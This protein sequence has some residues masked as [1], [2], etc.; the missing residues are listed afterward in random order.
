PAV[1]SAREAARRTQCQNNLKQLGLAALNHADARKQYPTGGWAPFWIGDP[2]RGS[3]PQQ[4][5]GW[6]FN[7][8]PFFEEVSLYELGKGL[9]APAKQTQI[10]RR[11]QMALQVLNCPSRRS[12]TGLPLQAGRQPYDA[13]T[14]VLPTNQ[15][16]V[17]RSDY[18]ANSGR[19][20]LATGVS[21][22]GTN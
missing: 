3:G 11:A 4:H 16:G 20:Y 15:A 19:R 9:T 22:D 13:A 21:I 2:D 5:G 7:L 18:A 1:Q 14:L 10:A 12:G 8:L 17:A 6:A